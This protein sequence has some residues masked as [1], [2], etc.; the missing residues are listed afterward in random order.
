MQWR[1]PFWFFPPLQ[2]PLVVLQGNF[3]GLIR[4]LSHTPYSLFDLFMFQ[5]WSCIF[6]PDPLQTAILLFILP[7]QLRGQA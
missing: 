6:C 5:V 4:N 1:S 7:V 2:R 3:M